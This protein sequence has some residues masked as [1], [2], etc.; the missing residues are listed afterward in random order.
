MELFLSIICFAVSYK[1]CDGGNMT[2]YVSKKHFP[3]YSED[4]K[5]SFLQQKTGLQGLDLD[6]DPIN[7][8]CNNKW[9]DCNATANNRLFYLL[10]CYQKYT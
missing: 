6:I 2:W 3:L 8:L 1:Y 9:Y 5:I 4:I 7:L 10:F